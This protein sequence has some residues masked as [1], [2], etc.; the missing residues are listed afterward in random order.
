MSDSEL[1][2]IAQ[3]L[4]RSIFDRLDEI[5]ATDFP[6][7]SPQLL[8][9]IIRK[10]TESILREIKSSDV[11]RIEKYATQSLQE[12]ASHLRYIENSSSARMPTSVI[13]PI[14]GI[15]SRI[16]PGARVMLRVQHTYNYSVFDILAVYRKMFANLLP[17]LDAILSTAKHFFVIGLPA[18]ESSNILLHAALGHELGHRLADKY[19]ASEDQG[20]LIQQVE[21]LVGEN[22]AWLGPDYENLPPL[23]SLEFRQRVF[24]AILSARQRALEELIPDATAYYLLGVSAAFAIEHIAASDVL[25]SVPVAE[26][27]YYPPWRYRLRRLV[28]LIDSDNLPALIASLD[29]PQPIPLIRQ[30]CLD[31]L[32]NL[33]TISESTNDVDAIER[34]GILSRAYTDIEDVLTKVP[35]F[36]AKELPGLRYQPEV[37]KR[38]IVPLLE[39]LANGIPPDETPAGPPDIRSALIAGWMYRTA[40]ISVP[41]AKE[42]DWTPEGDE[43]ICHLVL[44][45]IESVHLAREFRQYNVVS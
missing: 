19:L 40:R 6:T 7:E 15:I 12:I 2:K 21:I 36:L 24:N 3:G 42:R 13:V 18:I 30:R 28:K 23:F 1:L 14:E 38:E 5:S 34:D 39:R 31:R 37:F 26:S 44:K 9:N 17:D 20:A 8:A 45:A 27:R 11:L 4:T 29:G 41:Y 25:D 33:K 16:E 22:L 10:L 43:I 35:E 32:E